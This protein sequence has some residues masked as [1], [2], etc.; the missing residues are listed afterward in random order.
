TFRIERLRLRLA[1]LLEEQGLTGLEVIF[2]NTHGESIGRGGHPG[3]L[4]DR[5]RYAAPPRSRAEFAARGIAVKEEDAF[6][7][8]EGYLPLLTPTAAL[9]TLGVALQSVLDD[10]PEAEGDPIYDDPDFASEYFATIQQAFASLVAD[11]DYAALVGLFGTHLLPKTGS[12]PTQRQSGDGR[13]TKMRSVS[14][15][16][17]IPNNGVLQQLGYFANTLFGVGAAAQ[18]DAETFKAMQAA[19][20]RFRRALDMATGAWQGSDFS[21]VF[22]YAA[23][24]DPATWLDRASRDL[25]G[26]ADLL[27]R[28]VA[29]RAQLSD[30]LARVLRRLQAEDLALRGVMNRASTARRD[31]LLLLHALRIGLIQQ[32]CL[33]AMRFPDFNPRGDIT[34]AG[35]QESLMRLD[36]PGALKH[37]E[38][39]FPLRNDAAAKADFGEPSRYDAAVS[40]AYLKEHE[41][42]F[43]PL[44]RLY[45]LVLA[46]ST[47]VTHEIGAVG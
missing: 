40:H 28:E 15:L 12:R 46:V 23:T 19:S 2:F 14:E 4:S 29:E 18:K 1:V 13:P 36:V 5:F 38:T 3:G 27:T 47:A 24:L 45:A 25:P 21:V 43:E 26:A 32:I 9:T 42:V 8:G 35:L 30:H 41:T 37:L 31:R 10:D 34:R 20:P 7:G 22:A 16:R 17:A 6:Q 44:R 11:P 33:L 39:I